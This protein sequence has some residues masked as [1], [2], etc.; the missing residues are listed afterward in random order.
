MRGSG[1]VHILNCAA[2]ANRS[3][4][5][6]GLISLFLQRVSGSYAGFTWHAGVFDTFAV[7][8]AFSTYADGINDSGQIV[9]SYQDAAG[10]MHGFLANSG[11]APE[12]D[13]LALL[14]LGLFG[15]G[16]GRRK[17]S[18]RKGNSRLKPGRLAGAPQSG[19]HERIDLLHLSQFTTT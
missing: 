12:P 5:A 13:S 7:P 10:I 11:S 8:L 16:V 9:G 2:A 18:D 4:F 15:L 19:G 17:K 6:A 14:G 3:D 1:R